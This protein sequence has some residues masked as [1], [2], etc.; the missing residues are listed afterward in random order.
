VPEGQGHHSAPHSLNAMMLR[1]IWEEDGS[2]WTG[3]TDRR[4]K[5]IDEEPE[6]R[7]LLAALHAAEDLAGVPRTD[8]MWPSYTL[9]SRRPDNAGERTRF[10]TK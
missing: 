10:A 5:Q 7:R 2:G 4:R 1:V 3:G 6:V 9:T 8:P